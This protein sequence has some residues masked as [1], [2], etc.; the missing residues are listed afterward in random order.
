MVTRPPAPAEASPTNSPPATGIQTT[1]LDAGGRYGIHPT[2][3]PFTGEL[4]YFLFEP[5]STEA[6]RL[7]QKYAHRS[8]VIE[9]ID[10]AL[11]DHNGQVRI[12]CYRNRAMTSCY[13][14]NP[15]SPCFRH[16]RAREEEVIGYKDVT[17]TTVD[18][19]ADQRQLCLDFL[20]LDT[21]GSEYLILQGA[22]AQL[23]A[24]VLGVRC[25][26]SFDHIFG[27]MPLFS[28]I[29]EFMLA[30]DFYLL[31]LSYD[32]KGDYCNDFVRST[33]KYGILTA[34][35]AVWLKRRESLF[36]TVSPHYSALAVRVLKYAAFCLGNDASDVAVDVLL[37]AR[38]QHG[39]TFNE[40]RGTGLYRWVDIG[41]HKL[42]YDLK[43]QPGQSLK[44]HKQV[45]AEI[46]NRRMKEMHEYN[47]SID[48][49]P[50]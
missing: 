29:H 40:V 31:N 26:V 43:W 15:I 10:S 25:E 45:Y 46:F 7:R 3:K 22:T 4:K 35:D 27:D 42:F 17:A 16:E 24:N 2:W 39:V 8:D 11:L 5:D 14:R 21:E 6:Q 20:K 48:T 32:G 38:R 9:V 19:F 1:I 47:E 12:F 30:H 49:N 36:S 23:S 41:I 13:R 18:S 37:E 50:D 44:R 28:T 33:G 34:C